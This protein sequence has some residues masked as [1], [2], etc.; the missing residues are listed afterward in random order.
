M[1]AHFLKACSPPGDLPSCV[2]PEIAVAGRSNCG[3]SSLVN[4]FTSRSKLARTSSTPGR[5]QQIIFFSLK[6]AGAVPFHLVDLP[7]YGFARTSKTRI[8]SWGQLVSHYLHHRPPLQLFLLLNDVRRTPG[9]EEKDL[10]SWATERGVPLLFILTKIDKLSK[11]QRPLA[12]KAVKK[13]L[14]LEIPPLAFSVKD[15]DSVKRL[16]QEIRRVIP[17]EEATP[18]S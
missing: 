1:D 5:T 16:Q 12:L 14:N 13:S 17:L 4:A 10:I 6:F 3:K 11:S 18:S 2:L 15:P 8:H 7:G 9:P